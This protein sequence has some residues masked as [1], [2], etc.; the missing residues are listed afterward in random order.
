MKTLSVI[1]LML[2]FYTVNAQSTKTIMD[3]PAVLVADT[4][5]Q[6]VDTVV[7]DSWITG[8]IKHIV[9]QIRVIDISSLTWKGYDIKGHF[10]TNGILIS[11]TPEMSFQTNYIIH[12]KRVCCIATCSN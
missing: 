8:K 7:V 10:G 5:K 3:T 2:L 1:S 9:R 4:V 11:D 6:L 12:K